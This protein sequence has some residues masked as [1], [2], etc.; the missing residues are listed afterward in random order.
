MDTNN[1]AKFHW[2]PPKLN[3]TCYGAEATVDLQDHRDIASTALSEAGMSKVN[4]DDRRVH[5]LWRNSAD[6]PRSARS[7]FVMYC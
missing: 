7:T 6:I 5:Y 1:V 4:R 3:K 2:S